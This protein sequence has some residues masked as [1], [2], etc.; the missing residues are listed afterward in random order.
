MNNWPEPAN[1]W[2]E[3][4]ATNNT[5]SGPRIFFDSL[6]LGKKYFIKRV[7]INAGEIEYSYYFVKLEEKTD[8]SAKF[9]IYY[10]KSD[11]GTWND[12]EVLEPNGSDA[13]GEFSMEEINNTNT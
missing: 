12:N 11:A 4:P 13:Y 9:L 5:G 7:D 3:M 6:I 8:E 1:D 10:I 2:P